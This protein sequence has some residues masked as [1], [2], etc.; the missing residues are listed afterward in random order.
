[1]QAFQADIL[2]RIKEEITLED[3][4]ERY[5]VKLNRRKKGLCPFHND[6]TPSFKASGKGFYCFGCGAKGNVFEFVKLYFNI[7]D[8]L[9]AG[10]L[11]CRDFNLPYDLQTPPTKKKHAEIKRRLSERA[12]KKTESEQDRKRL[13][14]EYYALN[15]RLT[16]CERFIANNRPSA[17]REPS[18]AFFQALKD[19]ST[20][21]YK[22]TVL[23]EELARKK[24][25]NIG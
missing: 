6:K 24:V 9:I 14:D 3:V 16:D 22:I 5:G 19:E 7:Q 8:V 2:N 15:K 1:M 17:N 13:L 12:I 21:N 25:E 23:E 11:L 18:P 20:L 10:E 4:C